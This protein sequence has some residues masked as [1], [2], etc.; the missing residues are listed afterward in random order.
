MDIIEAHDLCLEENLRKINEK[1]RETEEEKEK[2]EKEMAVKIEAI[3]LK[4]SREEYQRLVSS[5]PGF[6]SQKSGFS[7]QNEIQ[8]FRDSMKKNEGTTNDVRFVLTYGI[9]FITLTF[10]GFLSGYMIGVFY[11]R[12]DVKDSLIVSIIIGTAT[13]I[14]ETVLLILRLYRMEQMA[15]VKK[16]RNL[17]QDKPFNYPRSE[18]EIL[19]QI[20]KDGGTDV[21][22]KDKADK[23]KVR[24][25]SLNPRGV[26]KIKVSDD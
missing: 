4:R 12:Y 7:F 17:P 15:T 19:A 26:K 9:G 5:S 23:N 2:R 25:V 21:R 3:K 20:T 13:L 24:D 6:G 8:S 18:A 16:S 1:Y 14:L 11:F 10:L 22:E